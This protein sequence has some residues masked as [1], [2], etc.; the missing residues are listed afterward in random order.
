MEYICPGYT[1]KRKNILY[2]TKLRKAS[3]I[4]FHKFGGQWPIAV[5][6]SACRRV[7]ILSIFTTELTRRPVSEKPW[8]DLRTR[9]SCFVG[10]LG[11]TELMAQII[12][13]WKRSSVTA[14]TTAGRTF[15]NE[16]TVKGKLMRII[17]PGLIC[18]HSLD[19]YLLRDLSRNQMLVRQDAD[20]SLGQIPHRFQARE[21]SSATD[22]PYLYQIRIEF[23]CKALAPTWRSF[24]CKVI[25]LVS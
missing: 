11:K 8:S 16:G 25:F 1:D 5:M 23:L 22:P 3:V 24:T 15:D 7:A 18:P 4:V 17:S 10:K 9:I 6:T 2:L 20:N 19:R 12:R 21:E 13:S 14:M